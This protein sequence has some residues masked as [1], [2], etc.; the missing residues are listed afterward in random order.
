MNTLLQVFLL[1]LKWFI[2]NEVVDIPPYGAIQNAFFDAH[3]TP[4]LVVLCW[5]FHWKDPNPHADSKLM[6]K[7]P[8]WPATWI[9]GFLY[10]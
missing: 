7:A 4:T 1:N 5:T 10:K 9:Y 3:F 8:L 6:Y 2:V